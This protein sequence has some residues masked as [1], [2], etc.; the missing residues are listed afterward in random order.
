MLPIVAENDVAMPHQVLSELGT[1]PCR[2]SEHPWSSEMPP[3]IPFRASLHP[4]FGTLIWSGCVV[5][6]GRFCLLLPPA[7]HFLDREG[8]PFPCG[9]AP[10]H[11]PCGRSPL[12]DRNEGRKSPLHQSCCTCVGR[13][14]ATI[15]LLLLPQHLKVGEPWLWPNRTASPV[16]WLD[17]ES[18]QFA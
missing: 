2:W 5:A 9:D 16:L 8:W 17:L 3:T 18:H 11:S 1:S 7:L 15:G 6:I 10:C 12:G 14:N 4:Q 13:S